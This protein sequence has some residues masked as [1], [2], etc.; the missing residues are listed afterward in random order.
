MY[1]KAPSGLFANRPSSRAGLGS[2]W[3]NLRG[4]PGAPPQTGRPGARPTTKVGLGIQVLDR[5]MTQQGLSGI[6]GSNQVRG[7]MIQDRTFFMNELRRKVSLIITEINKLN[8]EINGIEKGNENYDTFEKKVDQSAKELRELQGQLGDLNT[9][10]DKLNVD[11]DLEDIERIQQRIKIKNQRENNILNDVFTQRQ[12]K[13]NQIREI[14]KQIEMEKREAEEQLK[15]LESEKL[16]QYYEFKKQNAQYVAEIQQMEQ[17]INELT[18]REKTLKEKLEKNP[19]K[20]KT[21]ENFVKITELKEKRKSLEEE[22]SSME[23]NNGPEER[24]RLLQKVKEDNLEISGMER[25]ITELE[26]Q[27][28]KCK[29]RLS[30]LD[31]DMDPHQ[32]E[33][34]SKYEELLKKDIDMQTFMDSFDTK[35]DEIVGKTTQLQSQIMDSLEK[36]SNLSR[37]G[38]PTFTGDLKELKEDL[39]FKEKEMK[40][41]ETTADALIIER[42][43]RLQ[44]LDRVNQLEAKLNFELNSLQTKIEKLNEDIEKMKN[45]DELK[46]LTEEQKKKNKADRQGLREFRDSL[47]QVVTGLSTIYDGKKTRLQENETFIQLNAMEQ[48]LNYQ[49]SNN[50]HLK[51]YIQTKT[52]E[53]NYQALSQEILQSIQECNGQILKLMSITPSR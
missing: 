36:L 23:S 7:R 25:K 3:G 9:L 12:Q 14:E 31:I 37:R 34:N 13:E 41:S 53:S 38:I 6:K 43:Q 4:T 48:K 22:L 21:Y 1:G 44:D 29:E 26:E 8:N 33:N 27:I 18:D 39:Q 24:E 11:S 17:Q 30:Q 10:V 52:H 49:E 46:N 51:E 50:F 16:N 19:M 32:V 15:N 40:N 45:I 47:K 5:P 35:K 28:S 20:W 42:N 2:S